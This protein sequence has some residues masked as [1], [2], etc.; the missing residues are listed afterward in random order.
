MQMKAIDNSNI[1]VTMDMDGI[2]KSANDKFGKLTG[3]YNPKGTH[4][5]KLVPKDYKES[6]EYDNFW[7]QLKSGKTISGEFERIS[8]SGEQIWLFGHYTPVKNKKGE[9]SK[10]L[11]IAT[12]VTLQHE[13]ET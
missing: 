1:V 13:T 2:I 12:D 5:S 3:Y 6:L 11:K 4:H 7:R 10:V 9:Y 8:K